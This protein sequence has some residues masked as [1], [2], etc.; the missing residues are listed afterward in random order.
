M[1]SHFCICIR[2]DRVWRRIQIPYGDTTPPKEVVFYKRKNY[3]LYLEKYYEDY[4]T[5]GYIIYW[6]DVFKNQW[7]FSFIPITDI[8][9]I[10]LALYKNDLNLR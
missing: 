8:R 4:P 7:G 2:I 1:E 9:C 10:S 5:Y 6:L 3:W